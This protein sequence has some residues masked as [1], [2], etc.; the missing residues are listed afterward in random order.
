MVLFSSTDDESFAK[1][2]S[3][4][5]QLAL[6]LEKGDIDANKPHDAVL[7]F[8]DLNKIAFIY[9]FKIASKEGQPVMTS[10]SYV[11]EQSQQMEMYKQVPVLKRRAGHVAKLIGLRFEYVTGITLPQE[12]RV[13]LTSLFMQ[14]PP[15]RADYAKKGLAD[16]LDRDKS[17]DLAWL[18]KNIK[19]DLDKVVFA[20]FTHQPIIIAGHQIL[21][22]QVMSALE[23]AHPVDKLVKLSYTNEFVDPVG[24]D[25]VGVPKELISEY[26]SISCAVIDLDKGRIEGGPSVTSSRFL[27]T[28][29]HELDKKDQKSAER[30]LTTKMTELHNQV[31]QVVE[32]SKQGSVEGVDAIF[33]GLEDSHIDFLKAV[34]R[35]LYPAFHA[36]V[37]SAGNY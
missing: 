27:Q 21:V 15:Y 32:A 33:F 26:N 36:V 9:L 8:P 22:Q 29:F 6:S 30:Y 14:V 11:T 16:R 20:L 34:V 3:V 5:S 10:I 4:K 24:F 2:V 1:K 25:L 35:V 12:I 31:N 13:L 19:R 23:L 17:T 28:I 18:T 7:P 37:R